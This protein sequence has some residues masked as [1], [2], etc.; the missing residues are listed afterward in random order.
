MIIIKN[1]NFD[2]YRYLYTT[3][4][5]LLFGILLKIFD[6]RPYVLIETVLLTFGILFSFMYLANNIHNLSKNSKIFLFFILYL[7]TFNLYIVLLRP[8]EVDVSFYD[9][10]FFSI[11]EFRL[12]TLGYFLPLLFLPLSPNEHKKIIKLFVFLAKI[13]VSYTIF[14]QALSMIGFRGF[15]ESLYYNSGVVTSNQIGLKSLGVYRVWG[16][17]GSPQLLG[18]FHLMTLAL[19][20]YSKEKIWA[21]LSLICVYLSTSKTAILILVLLTFLYLLMNRKYFLFILI[22]LLIIMISYS[23]YA[24]NDYLVS[25]MSTDYKYIQKF[26]QSIQG[27]FLLMA[28]TLD[29]ET[30]YKTGEVYVNQ[31]GPLMKVYNY[32][33]HNILEIFFGKGITYSFMH[34]N[35]LLQTPFNRLDAISGDAF[36]MELSSDFYILTFFEQYGIFGTL[37]LTLI[38]FLYPIIL[39]MKKHNY[40]LYIPI[41]FYLST[42]HYPPQISKIMMIFVGLSLYLIYLKPDTNEYNS[43]DEV[44]LS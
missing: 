9:S 10:L 13:A 24:L 5:I 11:Q 23:L 28:N 35:D 18:V 30:A 14:E 42:F 22:S 44:P 2:Y 20:L 39:L 29:Y 34:T 38:Y 25:R 8:F 17:I 3:S 21:I 27:Y 41:I 37:L 40:I 12:S 7:L 26:V 31:T 15:F 19:L 4:A 16:F 43:N 32:F 36:Y 33:S 1:Y 6:K